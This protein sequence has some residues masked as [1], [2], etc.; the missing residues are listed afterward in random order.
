MREHGAAGLVLAPA[1]GTSLSDLKPLLAGSAGRPGHAPS[2]RAESVA[3]RARKQG[4]RAQGD[5][6]SD[7][8]RSQPHRLRRRHELD[9]SSATN[10]SPAIG[11]AL[12]EAGIPLDT[13]L[14]IETATNYS[15]GGAAVP[16]LLNLHEP[17]D[18]RALF[19][20]RRRDRPHS[21]ADGGWRLGRRRL[22]GDRLRRHRGSQAHASR[23]DQR[24]GERPRA[25]LARRPAAHASHR[26]RRLRAG[27]GAVPDDAWRFAHRA[28]TSNPVRRL[29]TIHDD[30]PLGID[31]RQH[32][33]RGTY[34]RRLPRQR[35]RGRRGHERERRSRRGITRRSTALR[36]RRRASRNS[37][38]RRT[39]TRSTFRRP[40]SFIATRSLRPRR[41][42]S[43]FLCEKPLAL[44]LADARAMVAECRKRGVVMGTNHHLRNA[45]THRAMRE[46]I[47]AGRIGKPLF[48]RVFHSVYLPAHLQ[49][50]RIERPDAGGGVV[51][52]ITVHDADTLRFVLDDEPT[53][54]VAMTSQGG[55]GRRRPRGRRDGRHPL[56]RAGCSRS[57]TT[58]SPPN[59]RRP[60]SR[61]METRV[62]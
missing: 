26:E 5:R 19:Q 10:G 4:G 56:L 22:R 41:R 60:G 24:R 29:E 36:A 21:R 32:D 7:C 27:S 51:M 37:S 48:A 44:T 54:V 53:S 14:V 12:E 40:T 62:R 33:R 25:R 16:Q 1:I 45:A 8:E 18:R 46:A 3:G 17:R 50:W 55:M 31:R 34:D 57:S 2:S 58:L 28:G 6:A 61:C 38:T 42:E 30:T 47:K 52:D 9:C 59:T 43:T 39:S 11:S 13:S 15:G 49:G 35:R 23:P 20:R